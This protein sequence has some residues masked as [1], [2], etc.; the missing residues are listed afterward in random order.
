LQKDFSLFICCAAL[1][2]PPF[3]SLQF[4]TLIFGCCGLQGSD[5]RPP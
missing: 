2:R 5:V 3:F 4:R 1:L